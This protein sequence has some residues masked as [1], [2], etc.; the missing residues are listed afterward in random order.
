MCVPWN[1]NVW[2][3]SMT[4]R[5]QIL[6]PV[7]GFQFPA[8][9]GLRCSGASRGKLAFENGQSGN[10]WTNL[11]RSC[12]CRVKPWPKSGDRSRGQLRTSWGIHLRTIVHSFYIHSSII[13]Y[14]FN[15]KRI[16]IS[17]LLFCPSVAVCHN[18]I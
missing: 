16:S 14:D 1:P 6:L 10:G 2:I 11:P 9:C 8:S 5:L 13:M 7:S 4:Y 12:W 15:F 3:L 17:V 18:F